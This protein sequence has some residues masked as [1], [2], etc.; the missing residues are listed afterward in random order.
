MLRQ[1]ILEG[2]ATGRPFSIKCNSLNLSCSFPADPQVFEAHYHVLISG[3]PQEL[4]VQAA[5]SDTVASLKAK[6]ETKLRVRDGAIFFQEQQRLMFA[7]SELKDQ[8]TLAHYNV[9]S[10]ATLHLVEDLTY[11]IVSV[12]TLTGKTIRIFVESSDTI[13]AVKAKIQDKEGL[14]PDQQRLIFSGKQLEDGRTLADYNIQNKSVLHLVLRLRGGMHHR[15]ST[16]RICKARSKKR[17]GPPAKAK[18]VVPE[19]RAGSALPELR[20]GSAWVSDDSDGADGDQLQRKVLK[21][22]ILPSIGIVGKLNFALYLT[23]DD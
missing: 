9:P 15:S 8:M 13:D 10:K 19:L 21:E 5:P 7:G 4:T 12:M 11:M 14:P 17:R 18:K 3:L 22:A 20:A 16:G 1:L 6:I 2:T 23:F